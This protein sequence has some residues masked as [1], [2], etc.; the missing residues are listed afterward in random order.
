[1]LSSSGINTSWPSLV[2]RS[3]LLNIFFSLLVFTVG[4]WVKSF[5]VYLRLRYKGLFYVS[6]LRFNN[7][8]ISLYSLR[9]IFSLCSRLESETALL[10]MIESQVTTTHDRLYIFI[11]LFMTC[12]YHSIHY[13]ISIFLY[14]RLES[15]TVLL[16]LS[17]DEL[18]RKCSVI[19]WFAN[20]IL[21]LKY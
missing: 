12:W 17:Q 11:F 4:M 18:R 6:S 14:Y 13:N 5:L 3:F 9:Y 16:T 15:E 2:C 7:L 10:T 20:V 21:P 19:K 8:L 1:M